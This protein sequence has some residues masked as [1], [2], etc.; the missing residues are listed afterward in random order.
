MDF[1]WLPVAFSF[2]VSSC[3]LEEG[4]GGDTEG[5]VE[6]ADEDGG[7]LRLSGEPMHR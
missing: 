5:G 2:S 4:D 1:G 3:P 6:A 7:R